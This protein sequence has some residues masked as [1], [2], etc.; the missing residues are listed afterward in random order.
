M[1]LNK[2]AEQQEMENERWFFDQCD[3]DWFLLPLKSKDE[4]DGYTENDFSDDDQD[5]IDEF[6]EKFG[7]Y[8]TGGGISDISFTNPQS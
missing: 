2:I 3:S 4:W 1:N 5:L 6:E 8:R 7:E